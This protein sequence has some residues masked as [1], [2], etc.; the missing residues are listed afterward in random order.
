MA[1]EA[2]VSMV[3]RGHRGLDRASVFR[4]CVCGVCVRESQEISS[5]RNTRTNHPGNKIHATFKVNLAYSG[6]KAA[7]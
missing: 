4:A 6:E 3:H 5:F 2:K 1:V 7:S